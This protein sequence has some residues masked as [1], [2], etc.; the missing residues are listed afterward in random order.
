MKNFSQKKIFGSLLK[1]IRTEKGIPIKNISLELKISEST[2]SQ[3]ETGKNLLSFERMREILS[4]CGCEL[5]FQV[6][7]YQICHM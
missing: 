2:I 7:L 1:S 6:Q 4:I 3:F 5:I